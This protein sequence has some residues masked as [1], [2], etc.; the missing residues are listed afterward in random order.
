MIARRA[1]LVT[2]AC[3]VL[4]AL[5]C[6]GS[7]EEWLG[8]ARPEGARVVA[9]GR[10]PESGPGITG[11]DRAIVYNGTFDQVL[12][13]YR[14]YIS[15]AGGTEES[16]GLGGR[17]RLGDNCV[18]LDRWAMTSPLWNG[19]FD[20][21][22]SSSTIRDLEAAPGSYIEYQPNDCSYRG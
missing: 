13:S 18:I 19:E 14:R 5:S 2:L 1:S 4:L 15:E 6:G 10:A 16:S 8:T 17:F 9:K 21:E 22:L 20:K 3:C 12:E 7:D 11:E